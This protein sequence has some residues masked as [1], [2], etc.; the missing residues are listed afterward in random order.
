MSI[1]Q[2][3]AE[4]LAEP[5]LDDLG[6]TKDEL[7]PRE[8]L[9]ELFLLSGE[10]IDDAQKNLNKSNSN[11]SGELSSSLVLNEPEETGSTVRVDVMMNFYGQFVNKGVKGTKS[12]AGLYAFKNNFPSREM[13]NSLKKSISRAKA[14]TFN[15]NKRKSVSSNEIKNANISEIDKVWGAA[16]NIKMYGIKATGFLDKAVITTTA[17]V[18]DRLGKAFAIDIINSI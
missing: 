6:E 2:S 5:F 8:T 1:S 14:S 17:K 16:R 10:F 7:Q 12:G 3:Q 18:G 9:T 11:A 13:I 15:T 4:L